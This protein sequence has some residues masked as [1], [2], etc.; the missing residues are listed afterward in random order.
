MEADGWDM[1]N[2]DSMLVGSKVSLHSQHEFAKSTT[3]SIV[4]ISCVVVPFSERDFSQVLSASD[5]PNP[6]KVRFELGRD[7]L[8]FN[9][10]LCPVEKAFLLS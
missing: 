5:I 1:E 7:N 10:S 8:H 4:V 3:S 9:Q 2:L 6:I